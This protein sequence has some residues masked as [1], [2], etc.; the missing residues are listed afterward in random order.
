MEKRGL[1]LGIVDMMIRVMW[2]WNG[3]V[4]GGGITLILGV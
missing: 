1:G 4:V 2:R 3:A